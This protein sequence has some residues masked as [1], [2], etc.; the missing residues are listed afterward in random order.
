NDHDRATAATAIGAL[1]HPE[2]CALLRGLL[3]DADWYVRYHACGALVELA[4]ADA[5]AAL[6]VACNDVDRRV[7]ERARNALG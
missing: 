5:R 4:T 1:H 6:R 3:A 7:A 2:S